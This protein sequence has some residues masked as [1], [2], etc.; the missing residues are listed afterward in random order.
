LKKQC[1][2]CHVEFTCGVNPAEQKTQSC[3][4]NALPEIMPAEFTQDCR[5][6]SCLTQAIVDRIDVA[7]KQNSHRQM[8]DLAGQY[9]DHGELIEDI[10]FVIEKGNYV[11]SK[12]YHLKRG[13]CCGNGCRNCPYSEAREV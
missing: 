1:S 10:D 3:W 11:F 4:C 5:C 8:L 12:W 7:I 2:V 9:R 13:M 6:K